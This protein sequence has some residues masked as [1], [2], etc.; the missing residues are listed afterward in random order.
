MTI[1]Q[2]KSLSE[3]EVAMLWGMINLGNPPVIKGVHM[4][5][6]LFPSIKNEM[7]KHRVLQFDKYVKPEYSEIYNSLKNKLGY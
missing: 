1:E 4:E 6:S 2:L 7:L 5:P 3:D